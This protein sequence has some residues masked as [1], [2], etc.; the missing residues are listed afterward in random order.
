L[1]SPVGPVLTVANIFSKLPA[2]L[3][4]EAIDT[5]HR[6]GALRIERIVSR[7]HSTPAS[8]WYDQPQHEWVMVL[9]GAARLLCDDGSRH[10]LQAG[11]FVDIPAHTRHRVEWTDPSVDTIWL[12]LHYPAASNEGAGG[13]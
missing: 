1:K 6:A 10:R 12:A 3:S 2:D 5:L 9:Q 11:D 7:G 4:E 13:G 8:Q